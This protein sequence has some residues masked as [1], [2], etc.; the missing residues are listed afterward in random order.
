MARDRFILAYVGVALMG[1]CIHAQ[2]PSTPIA[3]DNRLELFVDDTLIDR[4]VGVALRLCPPQPKEVVMQ[5]DKPWEGAE[6]T[7]VSVFKDGAIYRMYYRGD[8]GGSGPRVTCYA[9][10]KDGIHWTRPS[11]GLHE[12]EGSKENN[13]IFTQRSHGAI[14]DN[15]AAFLDTRPDAPAKERYKGIGGHGGAYVS[16]DG[17][18]WR[19]VSG[20]GGKKPPP[21]NAIDSQNIAF[22]DT[23]QKQYVSYFRGRVKG[24][25]AI[26]RSTSKDFIT[27]T[28]WEFIDLGDAPLEHLYTS[29]VV[30]YFRNPQYYFAFPMRFTQSLSRGEVSDAVFMASRDGVH[31][32]RRFLEAFLRPG[33]DKENWTARNMIIASGILPLR[34]DEISIYW[35]EHYKHATVRLRRGVVRTDGFVSLNASYAGGEF[36]TKPLRFSGKELVLNYATSGAGSIRVELQDSAGKPLPGR[37]LD[38]CPEHFGDKIEASVR[39]KKGSDVSAWAGQSIRLRFVMKDADLYSLRFR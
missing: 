2:S 10:S 22:W 9:E 17:V 20:V 16:A 31:F 18:R 11:L 30:P 35:T 8:R 26:C 1:A 24:F 38:D 28:D 13:I 14:V 12:H 6:S 3:I 4:K 27:W 39:W 15:F 7:Y 23:V 29:A 19:R 37:A 33:R 34:A 5:F 25:R 21:P 36:V 32:E